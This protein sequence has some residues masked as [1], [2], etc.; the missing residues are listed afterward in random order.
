MEGSPQSHGVDDAER[1][2]AEYDQFERLLRS[3][4]ADDQRTFIVEVEL[5][6]AGCQYVPDVVWI[7]TVFERRSRIC[8]LDPTIGA[9]RHLGP[10][11]GE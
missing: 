11:P 1:V 10:Q 5:G 3:A 4:E 8:T 2:S 7:D 9:P 6:D